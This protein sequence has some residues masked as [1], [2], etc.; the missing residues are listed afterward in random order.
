MAMAFAELRTRYLENH[1]DDLG[2]GAPT[3][4]VLLERFEEIIVL[5]R[6]AKMS[7]APLKAKIGMQRLLFGG[8][9]IDREGIHPDPAKVATILQYPRPLRFLST[10]GYFRSAIPQFANIARPLVE[11]TKGVRVERA[12]RP[13]LWKNRG[14]YKQ[15]LT[16][17][18]IASRWTG[19]HEHAFVKL[20]IVLTPD[21]VLA[22]PVYDGRP[23]LVGTD[24]SKKAFSAFL[25]QEHSNAEGM[26]EIHSIAFVS[27]QTTEAES[28]YHPFVGELAAIKWAFDKFAT[29][30]A[31]EPI[32]LESDARAVLDFLE[33]EHL[34]PAHARWKEAVLGHEII[35][36]RHRPGVS[37]PMDGP[38]RE[39]MSAPP[40]TEAV[41][42]G[43][44]TE[45]GMINDLY[46]ADR[47][48]DV[49]GQLDVWL[50]EH[51]PEATLLSMT[52]RRRI[53]WR[54]SQRTRSSCRSSRRCEAARPKSGPRRS[55]AAT[56]RSRARSSSR[57]AIFGRE[58]RQARQ[59][60][61]SA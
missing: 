46:M 47:S 51:T 14:A 55:K 37:N 19:E 18:E 1:M 3:F 48:E 61:S 32:I 25:A 54:G 31:G 17:A 24:A 53:F 36:V 49:T 21:P 23:F 12:E 28:Q 9:I 43:W 4:D 27:R 6:R 20:R 2:A 50:T 39:G 35:E 57:T 42:P 15:A 13:G 56:E 58:R 34:P 40:S 59:D 30:V 29:Y 60:E 33:K 5:A 41:D 38:T 44:E 45:T 11:L 52:R 26:V 16:E 8:S 22:A 7:L 10:V